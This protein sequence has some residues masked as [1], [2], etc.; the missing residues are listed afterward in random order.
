MTA[1]DYDRAADRHPTVF[2]ID[3]VPVRDATL[4]HLQP[5]D[6]LVLTVLQPTPAD[7]VDALARRFR[8]ILGRPDITVTAMTDD[9]QLQHYR[10]ASPEDND[11]P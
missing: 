5:G 8:K 7:Q 2:W 6:L 11:A 9:L 3:G 4:Y 10:P 1:A